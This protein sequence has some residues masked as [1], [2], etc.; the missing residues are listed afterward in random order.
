MKKKILVTG[1]TGFIGRHCLPL[2]KEKGYEI[3]ALYSKKTP[4]ATDYITW[5]YCDLLNPI[6]INSL[7][8]S[9]SVSHLLH[10]AWFAIPGALWSAKENLE[11]VQSSIALL[12]AFAAQGGKRAV[13]SGTCAEYD[14]NALEFSEKTPCIPNTLYGISKLNLCLKLQNLSMQLNFSYAWGRI[15]YLYG[16]YEYPQRLV[17]T[18]IKGLLKKELIPC[19]QGTQIK[20]FLFV[21]DV[22]DAFLALLDSD[23]TGPINIGSGH[24]VSLRQIIQKITDQLGGEEWIQFGTRQSIQKEPDCLVADISRLKN[25]LRWTPKNSLE[26]GIFQTIKWWKNQLLTNY[27]QV[28]AAA[29]NV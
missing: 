11:W 7:F 13:L 22:A 21:E 16:P 28:N 6:S 4:F 18:I 17:P 5:I 26:T 19:S 3:Y 15:F 10:F 9:I 23:I 14:W 25:E 24:G 2:L 20:D 8:Q 29:D 1:A 12:E 27:P